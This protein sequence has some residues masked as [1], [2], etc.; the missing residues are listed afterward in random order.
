MNLGGSMIL[1]LIDGYKNKGVIRIK[2]PLLRGASFYLS[3]SIINS[4]KA[5]LIGGYTVF[6]V[7]VLGKPLIG[8]ILMIVSIFKL[9][10]YFS[11]EQLQQYSF[12]FR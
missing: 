10:S 12:G 3:N 9:L 2:A 7:S 8:R 6:I 5:V 4:V 1:R 11:Q